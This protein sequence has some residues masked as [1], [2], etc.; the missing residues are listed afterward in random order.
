M[1]GYDGVFGI[2]LQNRLSNYDVIVVDNRG[3][4]NILLHDRH[5]RPGKIIEVGAG[6]STMLAAETVER[7]AIDYEIVAID[8][9]LRNFLKTNRRIKVVEKPMEKV[10]LEEFQNSRRERHTLH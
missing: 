8:P 6:F 1:E 5:F 10:R 4:G 3:C 7:N 2:L 9:Y